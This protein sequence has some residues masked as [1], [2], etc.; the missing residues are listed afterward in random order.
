[1]IERAGSSLLQKPAVLS[2][3]EK[4]LI[5]RLQHQLPIT[6]S[7]FQS[8]AEELGVSEVEVISTIRNLK[9]KKVITR[10]GPLFDITKNEGVF[11]LCA[12]KVPAEQI[13]RVAN[14]VN[15]YTQVAHNY[16]REHRWNMW[17][18]LAAR[19][20][21]ELEN[22]FDEIVKSTRCEGINCPKEAEYFVGLFLPV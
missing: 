13:D 21:D 15:S 3:L 14:Q 9:Q 5:N 1:M 10:F 8:I 16:L 4:K 7:P 19:N 17:F 20:S 2:E 6:E 22:I 18:V 11:S 12:L